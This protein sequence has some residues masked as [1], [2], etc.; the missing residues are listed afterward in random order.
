[1]QLLLSNLLWLITVTFAALE[2]EPSQQSIEEGKQQYEMLT[3][4]AQIPNFGECWTAA[5]EELHRD[6]RHLDDVTQA[7]LALRFASCFLQTSGLQPISCQE[8]DDVRP[9]LRRLTDRQF[10]SYRE[11]FTHTQNMCSFLQVQVWNRQTG[12]LISRLGSE[13]AAVAERLERSGTVQEDILRAQERAL[14]NQQ[15]LMDQGHRMSRDVD[16][17]REN[18]QLMVQDFREQ[19]AEHR[20]LILT[21]FDRLTSLQQLVLDRFSWFNSLAHYVAG[22]LLVY[23]LTSTARTAGARLWLFLV[24]TTNLALERLLAAYFISAESPLE[25]RTAQ[26]TGA[27]LDS[28]VWLLRRAAVSVCLLILAVTVYRYRDL[29]V[30]NNQLL[31]ELHRQHRELRAYLAAKGMPVS[32]VTDGATTTSPGVFTGLRSGATPWPRRSLTGLP[33]LTPRLAGS[34]SER[35]ADL[36]RSG[37]RHAVSAAGDV[38][39]GGGSA[40]P[41]LRELSPPA[42]EGG[43]DSVSLSSDASLCRAVSVPAAGDPP[44]R[45]RPSLVDVLSGSLELGAALRSASRGDSSL[46]LGAALRSAASSSRG[47]SSPSETPQPS[48]GRYNLRTR[49]SPVSGGSPAPLRSPAS[50]SR[51]AH[52]LS[53]LTEQQEVLVRRALRR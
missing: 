15:Q 11:F 3:H 52:R 40:G 41:V 24:L 7:R 19:T 20:D 17:W 8:M 5:L 6:C 45:R 53:T 13:A 30:A 16:T 43:S 4:K 38:T 10:D 39:D 9:C 42:E 50:L 49:P 22:V 12:R 46:E 28:S 29:N 34:G 37:S 26:Q 44:R 21:V 27:L 47:S 31:L 2:M 33:D 35:T 1:M 51:A 14:G 32:D 23:L 18:M 48:P 36:K 25:A